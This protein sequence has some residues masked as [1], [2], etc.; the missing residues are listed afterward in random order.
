MQLLDKALREN[1]RAAFSDESNGLTS[2]EDK[3]QR[4]AISAEHS[5]IQAAKTCNLYKAKVFGQVG[6]I[7]KKTKE[8]RLHDLFISAADEED[9][10]KGGIPPKVI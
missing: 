10:M 4:C 6:E 3:A 5:A 2:N 9:T 1:I 7:N 8:G